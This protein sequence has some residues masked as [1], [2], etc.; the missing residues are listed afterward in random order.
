MSR[1]AILTDSSAYLPPNL[2]ECYGITVIPLKIHWGKDI[3]MDGVD[4]TSA[5]F[6]TRLATDSTLPT[7]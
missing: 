2:V 7:T 4:I 1:I 6:Y 3:F 5:E